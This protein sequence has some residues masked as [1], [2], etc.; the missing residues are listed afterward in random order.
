MPFGRLS[1]GR[2]CVEGPPFMA[3]GKLP[4]DSLLYGAGHG[5]KQNQ[6]LFLEYGYN[7]TS[8]GA[9]FLFLVD[10]VWAYAECHHSANAR[11]PNM[12]TN[13]TKSVFFRVWLQQQSYG[14]FL[15]FALAGLRGTR[16]CDHSTNALPASLFLCFCWLLGY[17]LDVVL[18]AT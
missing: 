13:K 2:R 8:L 5:K 16:E 7:S 14:C 4:T 3:H 18:D 17:E 15:C 1:N 10:R 11:A 12:A 6:K 9:F